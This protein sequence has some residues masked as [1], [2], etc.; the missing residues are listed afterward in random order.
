[1]RCPAGT[2]DSEGGTAGHAPA[3][4]GSHSERVG[5]QVLGPFPGVLFRWAQVETRNLLAS[6]GFSA[7]VHLAPI[8]EYHRRGMSVLGGLL[9]G[10]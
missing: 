4:S 5:L 9:P 6:D 1:M 7:S 8:T 10:S 2:L 3:A